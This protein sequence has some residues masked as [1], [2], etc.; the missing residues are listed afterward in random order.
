M[1]ISLSII[2]P[3]FNSSELLSRLVGT[4]QA[5]TYTLWSVLFVDGPSDRRNR[6][7]LISI[8]ESDPRFRWIEQDSSHPG[9]FGAMNQGII[10]ASSQDWLLFWGSDDWAADPYVLFHAIS[11]IQESSQVPDILVCRG[12]Y[13]STS[14]GV[15]SRS[16]VF[17]DSS[18]LNSIE[19]RRALFL[20]STPPHQATLI[21]PGARKCIACYDPAFR[22][23]ADLNYFLRL[24]H[25]S[26]I[27]VQCVDLDLVHMSDSGISGR[28]T[29]LRLQEVIYAYM[30][31]FGPL[32]WVPFVFRYLKR[33]VSSFTYS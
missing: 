33:I 19:Y 3:T 1:T 18:I 29:Q 15:L 23:S 26:T 5:Q 4:L 6:N 12:R 25:Y 31:C 10:E 11:S 21:G 27:V 20:G 24:C 17:H 22:L 32:W 2:V 7:L 16:S 30:S 28:Q 14:K 8:C 13:F 9:I